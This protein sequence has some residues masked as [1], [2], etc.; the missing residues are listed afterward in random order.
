MHHNHIAIINATKFGITLTM[1]LKLVTF[2]GSPSCLHVT[3]LMSHI[4]EKRGM[5][6]G[7]MIIQKQ[8]LVS[9]ANIL[10]VWCC[11]QEKKITGHKSSLIMVLQ[12]ISTF[13]IRR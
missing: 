5:W 11:V 8:V 6:F 13:P 10:L 1:F 2:L 9:Y 12:K 4:K 7:A 3:K